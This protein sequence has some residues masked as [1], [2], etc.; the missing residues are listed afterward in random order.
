M[1]VTNRIPKSLPRV[2]RLLAAF[3]ILLSQAGHSAAQDIVTYGRECA[4][5][6]APIP[7]F[8]CFD[9][10]KG[11]VVPITVNGATPPRYDPQMT[12]DRPSLLYQAGE[13][14]DGHCVPYSRVL[15]LQDDKKAQIS[16]VCRQKK[17]RDAAS[18]LFD[19]IDI[20]AHNVETG[21]TCWFQAQAPEPLSPARGL[22]G[23]RVPP[24]DEETPP[25]GQPA[26]R[27]FWKSP[28]QTAKGNCISCHDSDPFMYSPF[29]AQTRKLPADPFGKYTNDIGAA[30]QQWNK[31][32]SI[33]TRGNTCTS[34]HRIGSLETCRRTV[35]ESAGNAAS[36]GSDDWAKRYPHSHWMPPGNAYTQAQWD[37]IYR[38][39]FDKILQCCVQPNGPGCR[40]TP[41]R[42]SK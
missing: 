1:N 20:I 32:S 34:C 37:V 38:E 2:A 5:K 39:S 26:A 14:T 7:A 13:N 17:I 16:A 31:P 18:P 30:F 22:N 35:R 4:K 42:G 36:P 25:R 28:A 27:T 21:S 6:V 33:T 10:K 8:D 9:E 12:C 3:L 11:A 23:R 40:V 24:P 41:I 19:E 15:V 29:I